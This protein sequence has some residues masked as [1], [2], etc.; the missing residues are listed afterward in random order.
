MQLWCLIQ[1]TTALL[2]ESNQIPVSRFLSRFAETFANLCSLVIILSGPWPLHQLPDAVS[3]SICKTH[4]RSHRTSPL[5][6]QLIWFCCFIWSDLPAEKIKSSRLLMG[7]LDFLHLLSITTHCIHHC[8]VQKYKTFPSKP[9]PLFRDQKTL[10]PRPVCREGK[11]LLAVEETA[12]SWIVSCPARTEGERRTHL[13]VARVRPSPPTPTTVR[14]S[15]EPPNDTQRTSKHR[16]FRSWIQ[17]KYRRTSST[18]PRALL[19]QDAVHSE[20]KPCLDVER[21]L[22]GGKRPAPP[23]IN[24]ALHR[25]PPCRCRLRSPWHR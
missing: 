5:L 12:V 9:G 6:L 16:C 24:T 4:S 18:W 25:R 17:K 7:F 15:E 1:Y 14:G 23:R 2:T 8:P 19:H 3:K 13:T 10:W 20:G 11:A 21:T 22:L